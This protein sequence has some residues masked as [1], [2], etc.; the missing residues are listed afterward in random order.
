MLRRSL[1]NFLNPIIQRDG[2][3]K[4]ILAYSQGNDQG[5]VLPEGVD[6]RNYQRN[7]WLEKVLAPEEDKYFSLAGKTVIWDSAMLK[8]S[9]F[10][11]FYQSYEKNRANS[12]PED[13]CVKP[14]ILGIIAGIPFTREDLRLGLE[15]LMS[16]GVQKIAFAEFEPR[17]ELELQKLSAYLSRQELVQKYRHFLELAKHENPFRWIPLEN[18]QNTLESLKIFEELGLV[19][20]LGSS[21]SFVIELLPSDQKIDLESSL[22]YAS[23]KRHWEIV[24][25]FQNYLLSI[26][27]E[28]TMLLLESMLKEA[29]C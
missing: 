20:Y 24:T 18:E 21:D 16:H 11:E 9:S 14:Q 6:W 13:S 12:L 19:L 28:E 2:I 25:Q 27:W 4:K 15:S 8:L 5:P 29:N 3:V 26:S 7:C 1:K 23:A 10:Q 22:R 17:S